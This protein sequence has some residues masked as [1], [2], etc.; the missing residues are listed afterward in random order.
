MCKY[1]NAANRKAVRP[2]I[3]RHGG[4]RTVEVQAERTVAGNLARPIICL[5]TPVVTG[6]RRMIPVPGGGQ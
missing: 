5:H 4:T 1:L 2:L 6:T 3:G